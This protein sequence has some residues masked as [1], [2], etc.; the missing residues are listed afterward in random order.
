MNKENFINEI[1]QYLKVDTTKVLHSIE[2][3]F[4]DLF[5]TPEDAYYVVMG[6]NSMNKAELLDY[7]ISAIQDEVC[8]KSPLQAWVDNHKELTLSDYDSIEDAY[9]TAI[10]LNSMNTTEIITHFMSVMNS[11]IADKS[12]LQTWL[13]DYEGLIH[14]DN[15]IAFVYSSF[16]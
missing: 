11:K 5:D 9:I 7:F 4:I 16:Y 15:G 10:G 14:S 8:G 6:V 3:G 13:E 12:P 2:K 1:V